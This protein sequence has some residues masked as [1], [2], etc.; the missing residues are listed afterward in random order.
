VDVSQLEPAERDPKKLRA[1]GIK[2]V[3]FMVISGIVL[4]YAYM[5]YRERTFDS[6][7]PSLLTKITEPEVELLTADGKQ[8]NLQELKGHVTLAMTLPITPQPESQPSL[9][10]LKEVMDSFKDTPIKPRILVFVLD[11]SNSEPEKMSAVLSEYGAEPEVLRVVANEVGK[12]SLRSFLKAKMRF[13]ITPTE[14]DGQ[15]Q[16]DTR[17]VLLDQHLHVR[18][19]PTKSRGWDFEKVDRYEKEYAAA[20]E[21][22]PKDQV[23]PLPMTTPLLRKMLIDSINYLYAN[24]DEKG[25]K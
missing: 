7:R 5:Q 15:F 24:P 3:V 8:R 14:K 12:S 9:D 19:W 16:Y 20:L 10:A 11:G 6:D 23:N 1:T 2:I 13:N 21:V 4:N 22:R 25:Q 17:L 18:G